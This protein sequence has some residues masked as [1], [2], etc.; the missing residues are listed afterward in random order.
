[1]LGAARDHLEWLLLER[2]ELVVDLACLLF[3]ANAE[4]SIGVASARVDDEALCEEQV[5]VFATCDSKDVLVP[6]PIRSGLRKMVRLLD[7]YRVDGLA[8]LDK[9]A[10][11]ALLP[12]APGGTENFRIHRYFVFLFL[13]KF[14]R[15]LNPLLD[16]Q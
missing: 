13:L 15:P 8:A 11:L 3:F 1:M 7:L 4:L 6:N 2:L 9:V 14:K 16:F 10:Q 5:M 12:V